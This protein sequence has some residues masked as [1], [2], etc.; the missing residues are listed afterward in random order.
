MERLYENFDREHYDVVD[1][2]EI[3]AALTILTPGSK[4]DKLA[5]IF[6]LYDEGHT[7]VLEK[8]QL[9]CF[10]RCLLVTLSTLDKFCE[11]KK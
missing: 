6:H 11:T 8:Y 1:A 2:S 9:H 3:V 10:L 5:S 7:N 4:S